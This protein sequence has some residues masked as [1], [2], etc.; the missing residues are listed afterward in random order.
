LIILLGSTLKARITR[1]RCETRPR[2]GAR[3]Q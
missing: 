1:R 2:T 3:H